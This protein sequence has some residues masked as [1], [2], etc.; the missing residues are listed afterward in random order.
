MKVYSRNEEDWQDLE[1]IMDGLEEDYEIG[2]TVKIF[3]GDAVAFAHDE[4]VR[5]D[6]ILEIIQDLAYDE[7]GDWQDDYLEDL[8]RNEVK[9]SALNKLLIDFISANAEAPRCYKVENT[10]EITVTVGEGS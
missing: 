1:S 10:K 2:D 8:A 4:F 9:V 5:A 3:E 7:M 6:R